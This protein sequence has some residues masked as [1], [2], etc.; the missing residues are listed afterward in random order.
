MDTWILRMVRNAAVR[1]VLAWGVVLALGVLLIAENTRYL[2]NFV[3]GPFQLGATELDA[4]RD[5]ATTPRYFVRVAGSK[6]IDTAIREYTVHTSAGVETS[7]SVS[8]A[9]YALVVGN[10]FLIVRTAGDPPSVAEGPLA[11]FPPDLDSHLF[12]SKEMRAIRSRFYP[13]Y[14]SSEAFRLAGYIAIAVALVL[15]FFLVKR[16]A[17][18]W[19]HF[20]EPASH[21]LMRRMESWG[22]PLGVAVEAE[23]EFHAPRYKGGNGWK[24]GEKYLLRST[25]F[26]FDILRLTD[27]LWAYKK[28]TKHSI[29]LIPTGKTYDAMLFCYGGSATISA[30]EKRVEELLA[31]AAQR[32]PWAVI[33]HTAELATLFTK[34]V[35][36]F[37]AAVEARRR[38]FQDPTQPGNG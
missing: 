9:Y 38:E 17:P 14:V 37:A 8:G 21:A 31:F 26:T 20:R 34:D 36:S 1:R 22:D 23:R 25:F 10:R 4:I 28:V 12:D 32:V 27:L 33:G 6:A 5:V 24:V 15:G 18:A 2:N 11:P 16:A 30:R 29:N 7:R 13:F 35:Q 19:H 3:R